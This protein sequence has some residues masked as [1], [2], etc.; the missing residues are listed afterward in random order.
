MGK[1]TK[2]MVISGGVLSGIGKGAATASLG[3]LLRNHGKIVPVKCDGYLNVD[4]GTMN[5]IEHGEVFVLDDGGETD[6]DFGH[7]ERFL[8][9]TCKKDWNLTSGRIFN[10]V[11]Q[12]ER[13]GDYL[14]KTIQVIPHV[15]DQIKDNFYRI[16]EDENA[17]VMMIEIGGTLGDIENSWFFEACRQLKKDVG[18]NNVMYTHLTYVPYLH[19]TGEPKTK[20]AQRDIADLREK[21]IRPDMVIFRSKDSLKERERSKLE[22]MCDLDEE[23]IISGID[24]NNIYELPLRFNKQ[25]ALDKMNEVFDISCKPNLQK[26]KGLVDRINNPYG[27]INLAICGKYTELDD[28]YASIKEALTHAGANLDTKVNV[29]W[30]ETSDIKKPEDVQDKLHEINGILVPGGF[31]R[32]GTEG[33]IQVIK[34]ARENNVP[35][36]GL[37]YGMQLAVVEYAR[38]VCGLEHASS[39]EIDEHT[40]YPVVSILPEQKDLTDKGGTMRLGAYTA[41][42]EPNSLVSKL[43]K[44]NEVSERHRHRFEVNPEYHQTLEDHGLKIS[45]KSPDGRLAEFIEIPKNKYFVATQAHPELKSSLENPSPLFYGLVKSCMR[46]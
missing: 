26:W 30:I 19:N 7:Y 42:V 39:T 13:R 34:Y 20:P 23:Q 27:S 36:L 28:A 38:N 8:G 16:A 29:E 4:P 17:D 10:E 9:V 1:D 2:W 14:G 43:Y 11:I 21:G 37:C 46:R 15:I 41:D 24:V 31:G 18:K 12:K 3:R 22:T 25:G 45:G 6:M 33:K 40:S 44:S 35:F 5:P 32:R